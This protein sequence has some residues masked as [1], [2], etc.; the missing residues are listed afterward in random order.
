MEIPEKPRIP[1]DNYL[2][3]L[4]DNEDGKEKSI[5]LNDAE[6]IIKDLWYEIIQNNWRKIN[7]RQFI[8]KNFG[9]TAS[10]FYGYKNGKKRISITN[11]Y[12]LIEVW[13]HY[14]EKDKDE[15]NAKWNE[16]FD[17]KLTL[18]TQ[19]KC[20]KTSLPR[21]INP[22][23][24]YLM[25]WICGD[26]NLQRGGNHYIVKISEKS[27]DQL[28]FILKPLFEDVFE[29][30]PPI[31]RRYCNGYAIQIGSKSIL[32]FFKKALNVEVGKIPLI[33]NDFDEINKKYFLIGLF[34]AEGY[35]D[36]KYLDSV[37]VISQ[38]N[39]QFLEKVINLF[40]EININFT[41]PHRHKS[42]LGIW[43]TIK[44]RK[45]MDILKFINDVGS[46]HIDKSK[47]LKKLRYIIEK[48]WN[49]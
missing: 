47:R 9:V 20:Q 28:E 32:K 5:Y 16:I 1:L 4:I 12:R 15:I 45:K 34:D 30:N 33:V 41:G 27:K 7:V 3:D 31:F 6:S 48:N 42:N 40:S 8:P 2:L 37:V 11:M 23:L 49:C 38:N 17:K 46:C 14:C 22:R 39:K 29:V 24:S 43:Y 10:V 19:S 25:G 13:Q 21:F 44:I 36:S 18:S 35:V 26:G